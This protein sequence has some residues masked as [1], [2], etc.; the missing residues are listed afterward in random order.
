MR[1]D[2]HGELGRTPTGRGSS[3]GRLTGQAVARTVTAAGLDPEAAFGAGR[4]RVAK[5]VDQAGH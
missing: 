2:W 4:G 3:D 1:I 5:M